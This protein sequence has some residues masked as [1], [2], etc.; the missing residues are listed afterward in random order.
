M[1]L[2]NVHA[3]VLTPSS[4]EQDPIRAEVLK[5][6][7]QTGPLGQILTGLYLCKRKSAYRDTVERLEKEKPCE[8]TQ[9]GK[10]RREA[11]LRLRSVGFGT[12]RFLPFK[13]PSVWYLFIPCLEINR[14]FQVQAAVSIFTSF[15]SFIYFFHLA[16]IP[17]MLFK[18]VSHTANIFPL[19]QV[20][21]A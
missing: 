18:C 13:L 21:V 5:E 11:K 16:V 6:E 10:S 17:L 4:S 3:E 8:D 7:I 20:T 1:L 2:P 15:H 9:K 14:L 19:C 12:L